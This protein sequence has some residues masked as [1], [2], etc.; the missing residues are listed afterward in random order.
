MS[1]HYHQLLPINSPNITKMSD[2]VQLE[3]QAN[4]TRDEDMQQ[5]IDIDNYEQPA[6]EQPEGQLTAEEKLQQAS[7]Q[8]DALNELNAQA[9]ASFRG[10]DPDGAEKAAIQAEI[11]SRSIYI[12]NVDYDTVPMEL[13]LHFASCGVVE[14]LTIQTNKATGQAKGFAYLEFETPEGAHKAVATKD[15][16]EFRGR[17]LK[18]NLKRTNV[19]YTARARG[20]GRGFGG[21]ARGRGFR[22]RGRGFRGGFRGNRFSPY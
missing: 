14:R 16:S 18:V 7:A 9:G 11:D 17:P 4:V 2:S 22:G 8:A 13:Q 12:G 1:Q 5:D 20:R 10:H 19:P 3:T 21:G 6:N 15:G